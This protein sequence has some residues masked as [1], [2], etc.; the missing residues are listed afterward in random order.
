MS[1][2]TS[3]SY[4]LIVVTEILET[5]QKKFDFLKYI[6]F[7]ELNYLQGYDD[8]IV[9]SPNLNIIDP[10]EIAKAIESIIRV[11]SMNMKDEEARL[12]FINELKNQVETRYLL[13]LKKLGVDLDLIQLE[14]HYV[15]KQTKRKTPPPA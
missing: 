14:Q 12:Y 7:D 4:S 3:G 10:S 6:S 2:R 9:I 15:Y 5:L 8:I 13:E 11:A 1:R